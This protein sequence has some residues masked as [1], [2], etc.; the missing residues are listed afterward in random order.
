MVEAGVKRMGWGKGGKQADNL[1]GGKKK[2][3]R[4]KISGGREGK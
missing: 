2:R 1:G 4:E 3:E